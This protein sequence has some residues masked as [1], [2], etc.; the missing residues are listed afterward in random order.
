MYLIVLDLI[1]GPIVYYF[2]E[3]VYM[4]MHMVF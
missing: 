2:V 1:G 3:L 4:P